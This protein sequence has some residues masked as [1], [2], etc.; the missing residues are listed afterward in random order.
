MAVALTLAAAVLALVGL[1][2]ILRSALWNDERY[3]VRFAAIEC[4]P[5]PGLGREE[6]LSQVRQRAG[7]PEQVN[8][9]DPGAPSRLADAFALHPWVVKVELVEFTAARA[10]RVHLRYRRPVLAAWAD[11]K[12]RAVD[13]DGVLLPPEAPTAGLPQFPG[14]AF[15]PTGAPG[16][17]WGDA[18]VE[19]A[20]RRQA[21]QATPEVP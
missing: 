20:A 6:F 12:L 13:E 3:Q 18:A 10:I 17:R 7:L 14:V 16:S 8:L 9:L 5:P 4:T 11:G 2:G 21:K 15:P 1:N 19:A